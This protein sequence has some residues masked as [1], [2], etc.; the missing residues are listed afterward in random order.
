M[1]T[2]KKNKNLSVVFNE[3][4]LGL[5]NNGR[6]SYVSS[7]LIK[8]SNN[9]SVANLKQDIVQMNKSYYPIGRKNFSYSPL[10][11]KVTT[12]GK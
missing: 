1:L 11:K 4:K 3:N 8:G 5:R 12:M 10:I 9:S 2:N 6:N 7:A